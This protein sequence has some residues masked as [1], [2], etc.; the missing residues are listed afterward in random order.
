MHNPQ[1]YVYSP[2]LQKYSGRTK[3]NMHKVGITK[4]TSFQTLGDNRYVPLTVDTGFNY[5]CEITHSQTSWLVTEITDTYLPS[6]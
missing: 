2:H 6:T 5:T 1:T 4:G 3:Y